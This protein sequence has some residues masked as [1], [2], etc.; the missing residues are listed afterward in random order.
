MDVREKI[1]LQF[2]DSFFSEEVRCDYKISAESKRI[3]AVEL[4][5]LNELIRVC[6]KHD[7]KM[8]LSCGA[9]LGAVRH[10][11][12]IPWDDDID[13]S[14]SRTEYEK[15]CKVAQQE[16][17][18]PYFFQTY[19]TD[20]QYLFGYAR[21]R[22]SL[23]TGYIV[24]MDNPGYNNGIYIDVFVMDGFIDDA[25]LLKSQERKMR[26]LLRLFDIYNDNYRT[27]N[28]LK[29][30]IKKCLY[31]VLFPFVRVFYS[32]NEIVSSYFK[33][34]Q[35]YNSITDRVAIINEELCGVRKNWCRK[36]DLEEIIYVPFENLMVPIPSNYNF[37]L[38]N[39]YG[40]YM[41]FPPIAQR[42]VWH[43]G[44]IE[45]DPDTP[46]NDYLRKRDTKK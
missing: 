30:I 33:C 42:G 24:G 22:N 7:I 4:D 39:A 21:L 20:P 36:Q 5:L 31:S 16:F 37:M 34:Q 8:C 2:D 11:G 10:K 35:Q 17:K 44:I 32:Y 29:R 43:E 9:L 25:K 38:T 6:K 45:F 46:Y 27:G 12:M 23:T 3:W 28:A 40:N 15:L 19:K 1:N 41:E 13:V 14:L 18:H 26:K